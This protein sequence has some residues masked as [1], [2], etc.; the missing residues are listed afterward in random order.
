M[1]QANILIIDD[2][3]MFRSGLRMVIDSDIKDVQ[4]FEAGAII[5]ALHKVDTTPDVVLLDIQMPGLNGVESIQL[6]KRKWPLTH[7]LMLSSQDDSE[8]VRLA[9]KRGADDFVSKANT[10]KTIVDA[11]NIALNRHIPAMH[12]SNGNFNAAKPKLLLHLTPRQLEVLDMLGRGMSNKIVARQL[13]LSENTVRVHVQAI[14]ESMHVSSRSEA[15]F[16]ARR[17]GLIS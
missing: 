8:T 1:T 7:V 17:L 13:D 14:F 15:V 3:A 9:H 10:A 5:E 11:V 4:V 12:E 2:H 16:A 6:L